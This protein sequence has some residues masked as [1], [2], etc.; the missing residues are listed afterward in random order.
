M[1]LKILHFNVVTDENP[2][3]IQHI[4]SLLKQID[5]E[6]SMCLVAL[7]DS[8][9]SASE[10]EHLVIGSGK[11]NYGQHGMVN[12]LALQKKFLRVLYGFM[13]DIVHIHGSYNFIASRIEL[14]SK[15][16]G[17]PVVFSSYG[18]MNPNFIEEKY[19]I[20]TW[21]MICYQE[22]MVRHA[23]AMLLTDQ[24]EGDYIVQQKYN[25]RVAVISDPRTDEYTDY[26][27]MAK[28]TMSLYQ[29]VLDSDM[30]TKLDKNSRE[31]ISA[32]LHLSLS[33]TNERQPLCAED[34]LNLRSLSP[35][36]WRDLLIYAEEQGV[37][38]IVHDGIE[39]AQ[40]KVADL[41]VTSVM[42][43][44]PQFPKDTSSLPSG[45][46]LWGKHLQKVFEKKTQDCGEVEKSVCYMLQNLRYHI[47]HQ[48]VTLKHLC[49]LYT[50][51]RHDPVNDA[52]LDTKL[53][54]LHLHTFARRIN[55][56]LKETVYL[57]EGFMPVPALNDNGTEKIRKSLIHY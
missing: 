32:L 27:E 22:K 31:A 34:I 44:S 56:I 49:D 54:E 23:D 55:Q 18:G 15:K 19:G 2:S 43:F 57:A 29:K 33:G 20:R 6:A 45:S 4:D 28:E 24:E 26:E 12:L 11:K 47:K 48:S 10:Y 38:Q 52:A 35:K 53:R 14:W 13:P 8:S 5:K 9:L 40:L 46:L 3:L 50:T 16:R 25:N 1:N 51:Y 37:T 42:R 36:K 7:H 39:R 30:G 41:D 21:K 17:F